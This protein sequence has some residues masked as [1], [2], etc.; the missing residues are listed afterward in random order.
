MPTLDERIRDVAGNMIRKRG[1]TH[2]ATMQELA[3][4]IA[5]NKF[6]I[7]IGPGSET[8]WSTGVELR[9]DMLA[10]EIYDARGTQ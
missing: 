10:V 5:P 1:L 4:L 3:P 7:V 6:E 2:P 9:F 8:I